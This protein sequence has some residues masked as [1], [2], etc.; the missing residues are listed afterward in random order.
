MAIVELLPE[1]AEKRG[2][3]PA[4]ALPVQRETPATW[5]ETGALVATELAPT[6]V[7]SI[8]GTFLGGPAGGAGGGAAGS[9][10]G[11]KLAQDMRMDWGLSQNFGWGEFL[12]STAMGG[13][14][15]VADKPIQGLMKSVIKSKSGLMAANAAY[16]ATEGI[17]LSEGELFARTIFDEKRMPT[18]DEVR[19]TALWGGTLGG[20]L[21]AIEA[22]FFNDSIGAPVA[23]P[24]TTRNQL[25]QNISDYTG[26]DASH[27]AKVVDDLTD[28]MLSEMNDVA[29]KKARNEI[30]T[31]YSDQT[32][33][34][35]SAKEAEEITQE[36]ASKAA[37]QKQKEL[38][39][40]TGTKRSVPLAEGLVAGGVSSPAILDEEA[41]PLD[42]AGMIG[43]GLASALGVRH[44]RNSFRN[45]FGGKWYAEKANETLK[46]TK[47]VDADG[48]PILVHHGSAR[49]R[50][51]A[52]EGFDPQRLGEKT[53]AVSAREGIF[54]SGNKAT[55][56]TYLPDSEAGKLSTAV[57]KVLGLS[58]KHID[59]AKKSIRSALRSVADVRALTKIEKIINKH[60]LTGKWNDE[61][62]SSRLGK[63]LDDVKKEIDSLPSG[64]TRNGLR[65]FHKQIKQVTDARQSGIVSG[66]LN[67]RNPL[68]VDMQFK[69]RSKGDYVSIINKAKANG[70]D[71]VIIRNTFDNYITRNNK[72]RAPDDIYVVFSPDQI[73]PHLDKSNHKAAL[74]RAAHGGFLTEATQDG[75]KVPTARQKLAQ[76]LVTGAASSGA[77]AALFLG[78]GDENEDMSYADVGQLLGIGVLA[79]LGYRG[80]KYFKSKA[81][82]PT[83]LRPVSVNEVVKNR[84]MRLPEDAYSPPKYSSVFFDAVK[85]SVKH[86][87]ATMSRRLKN[88]DERVNNYFQE[89]HRG[90]TKEAKEYKDRAL[91]FF[92]TLQKAIAKKKSDEDMFA[93]HR[94]FVNEDP[95]VLE[96]LAKKYNVDYSLYADYNK[97]MREIWGRYKKETNIK[98][99]YISGFHPRNVKDYASFR[100]Y[101]EEKGLA[102]ELNLIDRAI[103][104]EATE[105]GRQIADLSRYEKAAITSRVLRGELAT[106]PNPSHTKSRAINKVSD[107]MLN[108]YEMPV[109]SIESYI[110][111]A[112]K[113]INTHKFLGKNITGKQK[114]FPVD[115]RVD[116]SLAGKMAADLGKKQ[117]WDLTDKQI[118]DVKEI[119]QASIR[120]EPTNPLVTGLKTAG[121]LS[122]LANAGSTIVQLGDLA[123]GAHFA[124]AG[125]VFKNA[126]RKNMFNFYEKM[127]LTKEMDAPLAYG[128]TQEFLTNIFNIT[129]LSK[130]DEWAKNTNIHASVQKYRKLVGTSDGARKAYDEL[131]P[132]FGRKKASAI[133]SDLKKLPEE[134]TANTKITDNIYSFAW[135]R[136]SRITVLSKLETPAA[137]TGGDGNWQQLLYQLKTFMLKQLDTY[138][139][140]GGK[141]LYAA[142]KLRKSDP[143]KAAQLAAKGAGGL[144]SLG[145]LLY[146]ANS[147]AD[148]VRDTIYGRPIKADK[149]LTDNLWKLFLVNRYHLYKMEREGG[150]KTL[151]EMAMPTTAGFDRAWKDASNMVQGKEF[152]GNLLQGTPLDILY[153]HY[154]GGYDKARRE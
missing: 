150:A 120:G 139:E 113:A 116:V 127:G 38:I 11:N 78:E 123:F 8:A 22:R 12:A 9:A 142:A 4:R 73:V 72:N 111:Q 45:N 148:V 84:G 41:D 80:V 136:L 105:Q 88:I 70:N 77:V 40:A 143:K 23:A 47:A 102:K 27:S 99:K 42:R 132:I 25:Q 154:L 28:V 98:V 125:N 145:A 17:A 52:E 131:S 10:F 39:E 89:F 96:T 83:E 46:G 152:E 55:A 61:Q 81:K 26:Y 14:A 18:E 59:G 53:G 30:E 138:I 20:G 122:T 91:P 24:G 100:K 49:A 5:L 92:S 128:K 82:V 1:E 137:A 35:Q 129:G 7:G 33:W 6:I 115:P 37:R 86:I 57:G 130:M 103:A 110:D 133:I 21:G 141:D 68:E 135:D 118:D 66:Y 56:S 29:K 104:K 13:V 43:L 31:P 144:A 94:A 124:G 117:M 51:I 2:L 134:I 54:F 149:L 34:Y 121:Y 85:D 93:F 147:S 60:N 71:G 95:V 3:E 107:D 76:N 108:A 90:I 112:V 151:L 119:I 44:L 48:K 32:S 74:N 16:R 101:L 109:Q 97:A 50:D 106:D 69:Q 87:G 140:A 63:V 15:G 79:A 126:Y 65:E 36:V 62:W 19:L 58:N 114:R 75:M 153:W 146:M 67:M 64:A